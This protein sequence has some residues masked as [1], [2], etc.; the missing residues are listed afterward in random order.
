M[1]KHL[2]K[3]G[4]GE[5]LVWLKQRRI[6]KQ[7]WFVVLESWDYGLLESSSQNLVR[8]PQLQVQDGNQREGIPPKPSP[9]ASRTCNIS[10]RLSISEYA[11]GLTSSI[12]GEVL[13]ALTGATCMDAGR[14]F[15]LM[16]IK[17][18]R[19]PHFPEGHL[20]ST[21]LWSF[22]QDLKWVAEQVRP[23]WSHDVDVEGSR[24]LLAERFQ[25][26]RI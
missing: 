11:A 19:G 3:V 4:E 14:G 9:R 1:I 13:C 22:P 16:S 15:K 5:S 6:K 26:G 25:D 17:S 10:Q 7:K 20:P 12:P 21:S 2:P 8:T 18:P 23:W 24:V